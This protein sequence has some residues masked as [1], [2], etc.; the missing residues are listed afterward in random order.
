VGYF[1]RRCHAETTARRLVL[2]GAMTSIVYKRT[3]FIP[4]SV[5]V[6]FGRLIVI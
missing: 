2:F 5:P 4:L 3:D 6:L 1:H